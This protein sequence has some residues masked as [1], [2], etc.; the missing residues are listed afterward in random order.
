MIDRAGARKMRASVVYSHIASDDRA[1]ERVIEGG[2]DAARLKSSLGSL[3]LR[4]N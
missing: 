2:D 1:R 3:N 4:N